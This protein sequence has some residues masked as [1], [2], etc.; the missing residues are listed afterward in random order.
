MPRVYLE[1]ATFGESQQIDSPLK[2]LHT[3]GAD[4]ASNRDAWSSLGGQMWVTK[5]IIPPAI[6]WS[7]RSEAFEPTFP[8]NSGMTFAS[9]A[10]MSMPNPVETQASEQAPAKP[11]AAS[12]IRTLS[13]RRRARFLAA[14]H[15]AY[16]RL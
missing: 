3:I 7:T 6:R 13:A 11:R 5:T 8:D 16:A 1:C 15:G 4:S 10:R 9:Y 12:W 14:G 2:R